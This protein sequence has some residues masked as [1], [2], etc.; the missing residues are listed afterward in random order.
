M[1]LLVPCATRQ[2]TFVEQ[3]PSGSHHEFR[4]VIMHRSFPR[5]RG[6]PPEVS[7][8]HLFDA[9]LTSGTSYRMTWKPA[10]PDDVVTSCREPMHTNTSETAKQLTQPSSRPT[11]VLAALSLAVWLLAC[12]RL[13]RRRLYLPLR[14]SLGYTCSNPDRGR[15][16][17]SL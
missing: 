8:A 2:Q 12:P 13:S 5:R 11:D 7:F 15:P 17:R 16:R 1:N 9:A 10:P 6:R 4:M 14:L 3:S